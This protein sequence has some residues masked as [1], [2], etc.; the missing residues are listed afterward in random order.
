MLSISIIGLSVFMLA[1]WGAPFS[2]LNES[3]GLNVNSSRYL[4]PFYI[5]M[6]LMFSLAVR[7]KVLIYSFSFL[8]LIFAIA[9]RLHD[10]KFFLALACAFPLVFFAENLLKD[11][12]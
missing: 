4:L 10:K 1:F 5:P 3:L 7:K 11:L 9:P 8:F 2:G 12:I 6:L